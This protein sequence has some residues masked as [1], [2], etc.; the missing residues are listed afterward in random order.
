[1]AK[2]VVE[3]LAMAAELTKDPAVEIRINGDGLLPMAARLAGDQ[4]RKVA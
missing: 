1:M 2:Q 4:Q 3:F